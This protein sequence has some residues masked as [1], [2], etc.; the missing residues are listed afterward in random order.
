MVHQKKIQIVTNLRNMKNITIILL[1]AF[2]SLGQC[3]TGNIITESE[4]DNIKINGIS[5]LNIKNTLGEQNAMESLFGVPNDETIDPDGEFTNFE[6]NGF[7]I[8]FSALLSGDLNQPIL[9]AFQITNGNYNISIQDITFTIGDN[10]SLLGNIVFNTTNNGSPSIV[11][12]HC[13]GCNNFIIIRFNQLTNT[14]TDIQYIEQ[15]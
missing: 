5:L 12:M 15:S 2:S 6:Y 11:Y 4:F 14:I 13:E 9:G 1:I 7:S 10:I 8:G 3:Q